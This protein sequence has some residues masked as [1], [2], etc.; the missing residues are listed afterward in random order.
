[1]TFFNVVGPLHEPCVVGDCES[2]ELGREDFKNVVEASDAL[3]LLK[4]NSEAELVL[5]S[6]QLTGFSCGTRL[7]VRK[8]NVRAR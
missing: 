2:F 6:Y 1:M 4:L 8:P 7:A 5:S 3:E